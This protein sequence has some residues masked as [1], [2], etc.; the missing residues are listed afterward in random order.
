MKRIRGVPPLKA[1]GRV[2]RLELELARV[3]QRRRVDRMLERGRAVD[4]ERLRLALKGK[5]KP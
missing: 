4:A 5:V 3:A 2:N 1:R